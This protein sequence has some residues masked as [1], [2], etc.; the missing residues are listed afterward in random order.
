MSQRDEFLA[1]L[2]QLGHDVDVTPA[3]TGMIDDGRGSVAI[4]DERCKVRTV[5][6]CLGSSRLV[7]STDVEDYVDTSEAFYS[8]LC[9]LEHEVQRLKGLIDRRNGS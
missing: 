1:L 2:E 4:S 6:S 5:V 7:M 3:S 8:A 9:W